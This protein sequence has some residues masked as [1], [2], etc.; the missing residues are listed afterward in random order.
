MNQR[1]KVL[2]AELVFK[3]QRTSY[4]YFKLPEKLNFYE[5]DKEN[6]FNSNSLMTDG[7][8]NPRLPEFVYDE[9]F[10]EDSRY[11]FDITSYIIGELSDNYFDYYHGILIGIEQSVLL[12]SLERLIID[13]KNPP[14]KLRIYYLT[15]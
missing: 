11:T 6:R 4:D 14:V 3:P 13:G 2:R 5:T 7:D 10:N 12:S 1:W 15:Y 9:F 8:G